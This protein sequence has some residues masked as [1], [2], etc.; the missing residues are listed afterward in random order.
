MQKRALIPEW[1]K[2]YFKFITII[3]YLDGTYA[4]C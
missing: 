1:I 3:N 2:S 4:N